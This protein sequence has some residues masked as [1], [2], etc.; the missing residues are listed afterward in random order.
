MATDAMPEAL[1][2]IVGALDEEEKGVLRTS[3]GIDVDTWRIDMNALAKHKEQ[4]ASFRQFSES[5]APD[6]SQAAAFDERKCVGCGRQGKEAE[7]FVTFVHG[8]NVCMTCLDLLEEY[9]GR[10]Q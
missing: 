2:K 1:R 7:F 8:T 9:A 10:E 4:L 6:V 5:L 3:V